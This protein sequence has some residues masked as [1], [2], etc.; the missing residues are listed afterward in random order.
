MSRDDDK[1]NLHSFFF[2]YI[3]IDY[4]TIEFFLFFSHLHSIFCFIYLLF[5]F[6]KLIIENLTRPLLFILENFNVIELSQLDIN[7][8]LI[9]PFAYVRSFFIACSSHCDM[10]KSFLFLYLL[11]FVLLFQLN[12]YI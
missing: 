6:V 10:S 2:L 4:T 11:C 5:C 9:C 1:K 3:S 7:N 8:I 12:N